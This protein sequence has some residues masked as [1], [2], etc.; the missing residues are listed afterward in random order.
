MEPVD[1]AVKA[2]RAGVLRDLSRAKDL[3]FRAGFVG[4]ELEAVVIADETGQV[5]ALDL[6]RRR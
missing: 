5:P 1:G 2:G 4:R 6:R 3:A